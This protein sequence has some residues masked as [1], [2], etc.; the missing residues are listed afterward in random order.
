MVAKWHDFQV[1][2][3]EHGG[4]VGRMEVE[5]LNRAVFWSSGQETSMTSIGVRFFSMSAGKVLC[6]GSY[7][8]Y[9]DF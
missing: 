7:C 6:V 3:V 8:S 5:R 1:A 2:I 4:H 9:F